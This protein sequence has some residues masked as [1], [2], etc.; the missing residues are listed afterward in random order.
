M[1]A[2]RLVVRAASLTSPARLSGRRF[3]RVADP[4]S[5]AGLESGQATN[6]DWSATAPLEARIL[7]GMEDIDPARC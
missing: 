5:V 4:G 6:T 3:S 1:A 2:A 7:T